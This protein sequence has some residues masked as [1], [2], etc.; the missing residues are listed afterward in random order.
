MADE[1]WQTSG[2]QQN[3]TKWLHAGR[4]RSEQVSEAEA[5]QAPKSCTFRI[6]A[7]RLLREELRY[8]DAALGF[9]CTVTFVGHARR[10]GRI[11]FD[12]KSCQRVL[13]THGVGS[14]QRE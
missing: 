5:V 10:D 4:A 13:H 7:A 14:R 6:E 9:D 11:P 12:S 1:Q 2:F 8:S 3:V